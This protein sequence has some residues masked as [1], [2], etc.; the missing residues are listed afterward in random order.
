MKMTINIVANNPRTAARAAKAAKVKVS[1][2][3][4]FQSKIMVDKEFMLRRRRI[5]K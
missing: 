2:E 1:Q 3:A 4:D 5:H